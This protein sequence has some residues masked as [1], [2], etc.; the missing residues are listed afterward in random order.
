MRRPNQLRQLSP[1]RRQARGFGMLEALIAMVVLVFGL[2]GMSRFQAKVVKA[3]TD[4]QTRLQALGLADQLANL[5]QIDTAANAP[6]YTLPA[7]GSCGSPTGQAAATAWRTRALAALPGEPTATSA[8]DTT[9]GRLTIRLSWTGKLQQE[10][11]ESD[12]VSPAVEVVTDVRPT[13]P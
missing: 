9:T 11:G 10:L 1:G 2:L 4:G 13:P 7:V 8:Y 12:T 5:A 6:C 3:G